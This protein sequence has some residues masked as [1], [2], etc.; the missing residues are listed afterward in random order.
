MRRLD[1]EGRGY[2][3]HLLQTDKYHEVGFDLIIEKNITE[4]DYIYRMLL[5]PVLRSS[6]FK[7][8]MEAKLEKLKLYSP[9][10]DFYSEIKGNVIF[11]HF[12]SHFIHEKYTESGMNDKT[13]SYLL[14]Y[15]YNENI[16][17]NGISKE[18]FENAKTK[19]LNRLEN[20]PDRLSVYTYEELGSIQN[21]YPFKIPNTKEKKELLKKINEKD[22]YNYY[23]NLLNNS[24]IELFLVGNLTEE[25]IKKVLNKNI[26]LNKI[27]TELKPFYLDEV[28]PN[29]LLKIEP[30]NKM[31]SI[32]FKSYYLKKLT[33]FE[34]NYVLQIFKNIAG[35][36]DG[37]LFDTVRGK[38]SLCYY[39]R[40][41]TDKYINS[42]YIYTAINAG[43]YERVDFLINE[44]LEKIKA[45]EYEDKYIENAKNKALSDLQKSSDYLSDL[46]Q[47]FQSE[48]I[49]DL[50]NIES[51]GENYEKVTKEDVSALVKKLKP[52]IT[53]FLKGED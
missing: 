25:E 20:L 32:L 41:F 19:A 1:F 15:F 29:K 2:D 53:Y 34:K 33:D 50:S 26:K 7:S 6:L 47:Q 51:Q 10:Y 38:E 39:I 27:N 45:G 13:I 17:K 4:E 11:Y 49:F 48:V 35:V 36:N 31:Q 46:E 3:V 42:F 21:I 28:K 8:Q 18:V 43:N 9:G 44:I 24:K 30:T 37:I 14:K 23:L 52:S 16:I 40:S 12:S 22:L 5:I